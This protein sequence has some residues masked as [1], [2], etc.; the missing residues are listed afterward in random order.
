MG[1]S[2]WELLPAARRG[3]SRRPVADTLLGPEARQ[4]TTFDVVVFESGLAAESSTN[5]ASGG[6]APP[7]GRVAASDREHQRLPPVGPHLGTLRRPWPGCCGVGAC[8]R[9]GQ[10]LSSSRTLF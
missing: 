10:P 4:I 8:R 1:T 3:G 7:S 5:F 6:R 2:A 9:L